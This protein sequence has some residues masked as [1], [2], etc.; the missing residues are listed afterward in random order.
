MEELNYYQLISAMGK[1]AMWEKKANGETMHLAPLG[2]KNVRRNGKSTIEIDEKTFWLVQEARR[3][4]NNGASIRQIC[5]IMAENGLRSRRGKLVG[6]S[7][8]LAIL[9]VTKRSVLTRD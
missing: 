3:L 4:R 2:W 1:E 7:S 6:P 8:M 9:G 5:Q